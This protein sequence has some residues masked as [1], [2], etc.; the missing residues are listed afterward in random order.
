MAP[1]PAG[2]DFESSK[3]LTMQDIHTY[4]STL[5]GTYARWI[6]LWI[7]KMFD[8]PRHTCMPIN[9][10]WDLC[11]LDWIMDRLNV[12]QSKKNLHTY[13]STIHGTYAGWIGF[14]IV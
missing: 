2:L 11:L 9:I 6:G 8:N 13:P 5:H 4:P 1:M 10:T 7:D 14:W 12:L 3:R